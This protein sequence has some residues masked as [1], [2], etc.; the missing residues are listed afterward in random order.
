MIGLDGFVVI[1]ADTF[2][3][4]D[5]GISSMVLF[6]GVMM[7]VFA[8]FGRTSLMIPFVLMLP[9]TVI[10]NALATLPDSLTILLIIVSIVGLISVVKSK[11]DL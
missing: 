3:N 5:T 4:G 8:L 10:F 6:V 1:L 2:F 7:F 11:G 9:I